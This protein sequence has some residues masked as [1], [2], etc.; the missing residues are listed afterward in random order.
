MLIAHLTEDKRGVRGIM[1]QGALVLATLFKGNRHP[2]VA[3]HDDFSDVLGADGTRFRISPH[4]V[5]LSEEQE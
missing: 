3:R 5:E 2:V 1:P 4:G